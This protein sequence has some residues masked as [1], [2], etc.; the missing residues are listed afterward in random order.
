MYVRQDPKKF[1]SLDGAF[2]L[3]RIWLCGEDETRL[4]GNDK[5]NTKAIDEL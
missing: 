3:G 4:V 1:Y 2:N 5:L